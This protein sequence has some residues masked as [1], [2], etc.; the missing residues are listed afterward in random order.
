ML[1]QL[2]NQG[3][4]MAILGLQLTEGRWQSQAAATTS[5]SDPTALEKGK[6]SSTSGGPS[7]LETEWGLTKPQLS[8]ALLHQ[9]CLPKGTSSQ[10]KY[11][12]PTESCP[13][14]LSHSPSPV[15]KA[16]HVWRCAQQVALSTILGGL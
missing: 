3:G 12:V 14:T 15:R 6:M 16:W 4:R 2:Q 11:I 1:T 13:N 10:D 8:H 5:P 9:N 7:R